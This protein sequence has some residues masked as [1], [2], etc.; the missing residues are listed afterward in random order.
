MTGIVN[1]RNKFYCFTLELFPV[2]PGFI[3]ISFQ[4]ALPGQFFFGGGQGNFLEVKKKFG[5]SCSR[6]YAYYKMI[7]VKMV[8]VRFL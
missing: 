4:H 5:G 3:Y 6:Y 1:A 8:F 7:A 2:R